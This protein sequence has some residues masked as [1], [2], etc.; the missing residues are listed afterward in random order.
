[1]DDVINCF[2]LGFNVVL[3]DPENIVEIVI[4]LQSE[5]EVK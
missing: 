2:H 1:M 3:L 5:L 4:V